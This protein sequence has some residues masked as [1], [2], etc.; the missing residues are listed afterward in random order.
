MQQQS[1]LW[2]EVAAAMQMTILEV[3]SLKR[4]GKG[5]K[6]LI[7][8]SNGGGAKDVARGLSGKGFRNVFVVQVCHRSAAAL[9]SM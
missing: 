4:V 5:T 8:D 3:A 1:G 6:I 7:L 9:C 2:T